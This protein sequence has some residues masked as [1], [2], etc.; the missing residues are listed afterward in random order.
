MRPLIQFSKRS[1]M[2]GKKEKSHVLKA[3]QMEEKEMSGGGLS[4]LASSEGNSPG[5]VWSVT[6]SVVLLRFCVVWLTVPEAVLVT[7]SVGR[8]LFRPLF[9]ELRDI[10]W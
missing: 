5:M 1:R 2:L 3:D 4:Y 8:P 10:L 9:T 6:F 7:V